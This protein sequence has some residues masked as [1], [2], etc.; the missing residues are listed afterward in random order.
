[1][2][3]FLIRGVPLAMQQDGWWMNGNTRAD[4]RDPE[5]AS[6]TP[7]TGRLA[8]LIPL[9]A[10]GDVLVWQVFPGLSLAVF[11]AAILV[12]ALWVA[13]KQISGQRFGLVAGGSVLALLPL[14]ELVQPLSLLIAIC[15]ISA[16]LALLAGLNPA[17]LGSGA[18][19]L[20]PM[21]LRQTFDDAGHMLRHKDGAGLAALVQR[22]LMGWLVPITLGLVFLLLLLEANPIAQ[23]W[24]D[25]VWRID[26]AL[27][28]EDR[29]LF[30][31]CLLPVIWTALSL[32]NMRE[33]LRAVPRAHKM[34]PA[35]QGIINPASVT[36]A[37][38]LFN[39]VFALQTAM[40]VIY[41]YGGVGLPEGITYAE[42]AHRGAYPLVITA[43]LAG[44]FAL[45]TRRWTD[46]NRMLRALLMFWVAQNVML[47]V[48]SL[49]RLELYVEVYGLTHLRVA[50]AIWMGLVAGGLALILW[51]VWRRHRNG[52]LML[53]GGAMAGVVLYVC[54]LVSFDAVIARYNLSHPVQRDTYH[55]CWL[56]D[57]AQPIIAAHEFK[58]GRPLCHAR[59]RVR[60]PQDW[61]EWGFRNWRALSSLRDMQA[62]VAP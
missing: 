54:A 8:L 31:L 2:K 23:G 1:M 25:A 45:L 52:W 39:A 29:L 42:Y 32:T 5:A 27:P 37:L 62:E 15:G 61:R 24:A 59:Y 16:M 46:G 44:G 22:M 28:N 21:G 55:L 41:L 50:A 40:D 48:S 33:R 10:L 9:I 51:Q 38:V 60:A 13:G 19:R 47:V 7:Q 11:G 12:A 17:E 30:W 35:R 57:A 20:W 49:V 34:G 53:R 56:G 14:V 43:L 36:R 4:T 3:T 18:L 58:L 26:I 6:K